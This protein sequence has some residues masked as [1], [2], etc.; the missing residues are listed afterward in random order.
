MAIPRE[1]VKRLYDEGARSYD[2]T[3]ILF[4]LAGLRMQKYRSEVIDCLD[5]RS[6][7][8]VL[9]LGCGTGLNFPLILEK[10]GPQGK[11]IGVD[12]AK[13][14]LD[15]A[16]SKA[17]MNNWNNVELIESDLA[18]LK[19]P[20]GVDAVLSTGVFGY[21]PEYERVIENAYDALSSGGHIAILDG[22]K[23]ENLPGI[24]FKF[25][26][27]IGKQYGY[28]EEYFQVSPWEAVESLFSNTTFNTRYGG[29]IYEISGVKS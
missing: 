24:I 10:V 25:I 2:L 19:F 15:V 9:E 11:I 16:R 22:K 20:E 3:T 28:T 17:I 7:N 14:M 6:G 26:L 29:M 23:P 12:I 13:G 8:T 27:A 5:L 21:I 4:R 18:L 1:R